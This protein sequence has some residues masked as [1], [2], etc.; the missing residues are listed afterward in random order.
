[1]Y[2]ISSTFKSNAMHE[3]IINTLKNSKSY[4]CH[5]YVVSSLAEC[6]VVLDIHHQFTTMHQQKYHKGWKL[7]TESLTKKKIFARQKTYKYYRKT[8]W[9]AWWVNGEKSR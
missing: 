1:M 5:P 9:Y 7:S 2:C 3:A 8:N 6:P 4:H